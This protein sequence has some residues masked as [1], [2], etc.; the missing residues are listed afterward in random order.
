M[1]LI[2]NKAPAKAAAT[3]LLQDEA[4]HDNG[5]KGR[6]LVEHVGVGDDH[7]VYG[8]EIAENADR[9]EQGTQEQAADTIPVDGKFFR[10]PCQGDKSNY[11]GDQIAEKGF[12]HGGDIPGQLYKNAHQGEE[13]GSHNNADDA[14]YVFALYTAFDLHGQL[15]LWSCNILYRYGSYHNTFRT[16]FQIH[17]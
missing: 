11:R 7:V 14:F 13:K 2:T 6:Q 16:G 12:L 1:G 3:S 4:G 10:R 5:K 15:L 9:A 17:F 8:P